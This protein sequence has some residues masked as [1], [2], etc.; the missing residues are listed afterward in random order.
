MIQKQINIEG[1]QIFYRI[2]GSGNPVV[3]IHGF[4]EDS[5]VWNKQ[6]ESLKS[7]FQFI[8]PDLPGSGRSEMIDDMSVEGMAEVVKYILDSECPKVLPLGED[9]GGATPTQLRGLAP[10]GASRG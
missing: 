3:L 7:H 2:I 8:V 6:V 10:A 5:T 4:G 1:K 9:L